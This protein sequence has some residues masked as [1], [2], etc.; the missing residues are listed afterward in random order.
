MSQLLDKT[1]VLYFEPQ[2]IG[3]PDGARCGICWKFDP[4]ARACVE[5]DGTIS[6]TRGICG[7]YING[8]PAGNKIPVSSLPAR[9]ISKEEAGYSEEGPTHCGNCDEMFNRT[10][11][12]NSI[13][14][15]VKGMVEGRGCCNVWEKA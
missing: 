13:C 2:S 15:K 5:V 8:D 9:K 6:G 12:G 1:E 11:Y 7:L 3:S 10:V 4:F 14:K